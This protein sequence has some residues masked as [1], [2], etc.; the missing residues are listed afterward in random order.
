M[1]DIDCKNVR[2]QIKIENNNTELYTLNKPKK[3]KT[4]E[5]ELAT[6]CKQTIRCK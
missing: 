3:A 1:K 4:V 2:T 5:R 6:R